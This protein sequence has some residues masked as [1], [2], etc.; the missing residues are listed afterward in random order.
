MQR[1][2]AIVLAEGLF[3]TGS[4]KTAHGLVR[5]SSRFTVAGVVDASNAG[6][7]AG[8]ALDGRPRSIPIFPSVAAACAALP[9]APRVAIVGVATS[10]GRI[11]PS[12]RASLREAVLRGMSIVNGLHEGVAEDPEIAELA[13]QKGVQIID[14]RRPRPRSELHFWTGEIRHVTTPRLAVLGTDCAIG[15]RT[16]TRFLVEACNAAGLRT[17]MIHT[18]QT[19]WMQGADYGVILDCLPND[20]VAG[21]LE[22]AVLCCFRERRPDLMILEGQSALRNPAGPCGAELLLSAGAKGVIVQHA[23]G[24]T[25]YDDFEEAGFKI[26]DLGEELE[27]I[28]LYGSRT[29]AVTLNSEGLD[30]EALFRHKGEIEK[31]LGLP[32]VCP[33]EEGV[34]RLVP[35]V[36]RFVEES[37]AH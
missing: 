15:K 37:V 30:R 28:R 36:R 27:L 20:F 14:I 29:L 9:E 35:L 2:T 5:G 10:G 13:R 32:V 16:T 21:E 11:P 4:A 19:G 25:F 6:R 17:E 22:H 33:L 7:D 3:S 18:G 1:E 31:R 8:E 12:L 34:D 23:P 26:G 24:R